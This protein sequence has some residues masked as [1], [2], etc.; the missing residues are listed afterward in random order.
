MAIA[1]AIDG[2]NC[3]QAE[4]DL[5]SCRSRQLVF[6]AHHQALLAQKLST[7]LEATGQQISEEVGD[8]VTKYLDG[9]LLSGP[10]SGESFF[11]IQLSQ[12]TNWRDCQVI[13]GHPTGVVSQT[14]A[15]LVFLQSVSFLILHN[16]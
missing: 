13:V 8:T 7:K 6:A 10:T 12:V 11:A 9:A 2:R 15:N 14:L 1:Y 16:D 5:A 3:I 4:V